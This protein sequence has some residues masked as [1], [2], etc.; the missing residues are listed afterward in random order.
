M[1]FSYII[2]RIVVVLYCRL[3]R[4]VYF[5][6]SGG[7]IVYSVFFCL[8]FLSCWLLQSWMYS[9]FKKSWPNFYIV[10]LSNGS[11]LLGHSVCIEQISILPQT[12]RVGYICTN[13]FL[14]ASLVVDMFFLLFWWSYSIFLSL[15]PFL[16]NPGRTVCPTSLDTIYI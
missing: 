16:S 11:L 6:F 2:H 1:S 5:Y 8:S 15:F 12:K 10:T 9:M 14:V 4:Y 13:A 3:C 7:L